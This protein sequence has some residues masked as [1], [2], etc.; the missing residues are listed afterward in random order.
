MERPSRAVWTKHDHA[1]AEEEMRSASHSHK[2]TKGICKLSR[3]QFIS[4]VLGILA[5]AP[6]SDDEQKV[7]K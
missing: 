4:L 3:L 2:G 5:I 7:D 6:P 1:S